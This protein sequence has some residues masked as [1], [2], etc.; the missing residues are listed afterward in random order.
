MPRSNELYLMVMPLIH[1]SNLP[2]TG[3]G[4]TEQVL[5][6][7]PDRNFATEFLPSEVDGFLETFK[8]R[9]KVYLTGGSVTGYDFYKEET[10]DGRVIVRVVQNV[11]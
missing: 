5:T 9:A 11:A 2:Y 10:E 8:S 7:F 4:L 3:Y 6:V 1:I